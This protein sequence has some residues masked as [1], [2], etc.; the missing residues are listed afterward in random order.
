MSMGELTTQA[1][2]QMPNGCFIGER[3]F[4]GHGPL[5]RHLFEVNY[6]GPIET[7]NHVVYT[8][9]D[10]FRDADGK[11]TEGIGYTPTYEV[12]YDEEKMR[13]GVDVQLNAALNYI[14]TGSIN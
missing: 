2:A 6:A 14:R 4:G 1:I 5:F 11:I 7:N 12:L 9:N 8:S 10:V 13:A 3:T